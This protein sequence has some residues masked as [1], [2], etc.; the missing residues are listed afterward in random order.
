MNRNL[1]ALA[2]QSFDV[3]VIGGG[4]FGAGIAR[5]AVLRGLRVALIDRSDFGGA[6]SSCSSKLIHGGFRYLE[7]YAFG[8]VAEAC[9]ERRIQQTV[10]P[11][12]VRPRSFLLPVYDGDPRSLGL[13]RLGMTLYDLIALYRNTAPHRLL[14]AER[15]LKAEPALARTGLRGAVQFYDC[16]MDDARLCLENIID[17]AERG[18]VCANY[19]ELTGFVIR[20]DRL[21]AGRVLDRLG[22]GNFEVTARVFVNAAGPWVDRVAN[23]TQFNGQ[24][25]ALS[26]TKGVHLVLPRL[27]QEHGIFFQAKRDGRM[28][29]VIPWGDY[30]LVGTT[31]TDF[32]GDPGEARAE[33]PD[34]EYLLSEVRALMP[35]ISLGESDVITT[36]TG[37]RALL[38]SDV[39]NPSARSREHRIARHGRNLLSVAG[40]KYTTYRAIAEQTVNEVYRVL[41]LRPPAYVTAK[42]P[43]PDHRPPPVGEKIA[44]SPI[45]HASDIRHACEFEMAMTVADVMR[46]RTGL[47][48]SRY[49]GP[50]TAGRVASLMAPLLGWDDQQMRSSLRQ[51]VE[52]WKRNLP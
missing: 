21:V 11:H 38:R 15:T 19:C 3:L 42:T 22:A 32:A 26:P 41:D 43:L 47:A 18:A 14:S 51:Y 2:D 25:V 17:A 36:F 34:I 27:T 30:S 52:E 9:R 39:A 4:I 50:E 24:R 40:G 23:F 44:D 35:E 29:F 7:Q 45:V 37:V 49:G 16:Q 31:D 1:R 5:D 13:V 46:R 6:T 8:L 28:M 10:A 33:P 48:L 20:D 12:L